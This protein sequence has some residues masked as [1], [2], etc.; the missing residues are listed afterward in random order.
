MTFDK[1]FCDNTCT[2]HKLNSKF[3]MKGKDKSFGDKS[4]HYL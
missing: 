3:R 4:V 1:T 2:A